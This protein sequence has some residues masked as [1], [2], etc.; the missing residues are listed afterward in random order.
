MNESIVFETNGQWMITADEIFITT[1]AVGESPAI[2]TPAP[3]P[4][5]RRSFGHWKNPSMRFP[6]IAGVSN[7]CSSV[8]VSNY[9]LKTQTQP[10]TNINKELCDVILVVAVMIPLPRGWTD[11]PWGRQDFLEDW[12]WLLW[13]SGH[14]C[15]VPCGLVRSHHW[16]LCP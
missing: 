14:A 15:S 7:L 13:P 1:G 4:P 5:P 6:T 2:P 9:F 11:R 16:L 10:R 8:L 12:W 3:P